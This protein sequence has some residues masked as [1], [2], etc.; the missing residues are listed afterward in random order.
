MNDL[1]VIS[2]Y[3]QFKEQIKVLFKIPQ[4]ATSRENRNGLYSVP[5]GKNNVQ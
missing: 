3:V 4:D 1:N 5:I 2:Q